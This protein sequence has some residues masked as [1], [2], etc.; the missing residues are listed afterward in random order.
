MDKQ[1][2]VFIVEDDPRIQE[3]E[4]IALQR[5]GIASERFSKGEDFLKAIAS[6]KPDLVLLD[7][8]L[9]GIS[10]IAVLRELKKHPETAHLPVLM[11]TAKTS[12]MDEILSMENGADDYITKPFN[13]RVLVLHVQA[14][15]RRAHVPE[16]HTTLDVLGI[17]MDLDAMTCSVD[18]VPVE[19]ATKEFELLAMLAKNV[20]KAMSRDVLMDGIWHTEYVGNSR[21]L[22]IHINRIRKKLGKTGERIHTVW[23]IG[24]KLS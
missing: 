3:I 5:A 12:D 23:G 19:L 11:V 1:D 15:L 13:N 8:M 24:Y 20:G 18:G 10:G 17:H 22:D 21:T 2:I 9:P 6:K 14:L 16:K 7:I 4:A